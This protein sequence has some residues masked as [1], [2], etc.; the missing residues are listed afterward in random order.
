MFVTCTCW[1]NELES[2]TYTE[3][4]G[5]ERHVPADRW[6][7]PSWF[8]ASSHIVPLPA[9]GPPR[10]NTTLG[11]RRGSCSCTVILGAGATPLDGGGG[12]MSE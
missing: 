2:G 4:V 9:P 7:Q 12:G 11:L 6:H 5:Q 10:T 1:V 3:T 8:I